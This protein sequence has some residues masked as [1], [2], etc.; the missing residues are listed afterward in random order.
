MICGQ[1]LRTLE[2]L[3]KRRDLEKQMALRGAAPNPLLNY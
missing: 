1:P 3:E 2:G